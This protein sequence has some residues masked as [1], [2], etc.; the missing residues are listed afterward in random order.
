MGLFGRKTTRTRAL[1]E[2]AKAHKYRFEAKDE[3]GVSAY[4]G[5]MKLFRQGSNKH[6]RHVMERRSKMFEHRGAMDYYYTVSTGKSSA[7]YKQTIYYRVNQELMLPAFVLFPEKWFHRIG[8]WF[9]MQDIN[10]I[11]YPDFSKSYLL[12]GAQSHFIEKFFA[13]AR[14]IRHF[15]MYKGYSVEAVG[16]FFVMYKPNVLVPVRDMKQF[17]AIGDKLF[18]LMKKRNIEMEKIFDPPESE[19]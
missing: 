11:E 5:D 6:G 18:G 7:T 14:L 2:F 13:D 4:F 10:F 17:I 19:D 1:E 16:K 9:G 8:K 12:Q 3:M 15:T